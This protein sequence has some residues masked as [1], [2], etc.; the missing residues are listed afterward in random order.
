MSKAESRILQA[1]RAE[2]V[3]ILGSL[4]CFPNHFGEMP[5]L[6]PNAVDMTIMQCND[7]KDHVISMLLKAGKKEPSGVARCIAI[8]CVG[9]FLYDELTHN[10][11]HPRLKE[12]INVL[13]AILRVGFHL[14][15]LNLLYI[16]VEPMTD[17]I[18]S[19]VIFMPPVYIY[20]TFFCGKGS[21][22][23]QIKASCSSVDVRYKFFHN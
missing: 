13:L 14:I 12:A 10:T 1:P 22:F 4:I 2:A 18:P 21:R 15:G 23:Y 11:Q 20:E 16:T 17:H 8:S 19:Q 3:S 6:Q 5:V 9:I 7:V